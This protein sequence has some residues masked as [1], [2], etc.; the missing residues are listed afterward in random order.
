M[1]P[2]DVDATG[3][4]GQHVALP[5][6]IHHQWLLGSYQ[7]SIIWCDPTPRSSVGTTALLGFGE[8]LDDY[9]VGQFG[10]LIRVEQKLAGAI[11]AT[12]NHPGL[13]HDRAVDVDRQITN[14]KSSY[15]TDH[16]ACEFHGG[17]FVGERKTLDG[18]QFTDLL[19][20]VQPS[21]TQHDACGVLRRGDLL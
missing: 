2:I 8:A 3:L 12:H 16:H 14:S 11:A 5:I 20:D 10:E 9:N 15:P 18:E 6:A 4:G 17:L 13:L 19:V 7:A 1:N 21:C